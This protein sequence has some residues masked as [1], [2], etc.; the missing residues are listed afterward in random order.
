MGWMIIG[1]WR[2]ALEGI[3]KSAEMLENGGSAGDCVENAIKMVE[4]CPYYESVGCG[5]LP[6]ENGEV[7]LDAGYM[8]GDSLSFGA[9]GGIRDFKNPVSIARRLSQEKVNCFLT[10]SG[11]EEFAHRSGFERKNML[12]ESAAM[13]YRNKL[14]ETGRDLIPYEGHDTVGV[15]ALDKNHSVACGTSTSGLFMKRRGRL[16]DS[17]VC[18]PGFYADSRVG[19]CVATGLGEDIMKGCV[20][21]EA[22]RLME[23]GH[24]PQDAADIAVSKLCGRFAERHR[25]IGDVSVVCLNNRGEFGAATN[26]G[27]FSFAAAAEGLPPAVYVCSVRDGRTVYEAEA[28]NI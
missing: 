16:G 12:T 26:I 19:G 13:R 8:D 2:M 5:G 27:E 20:S 11:A 23:E 9:V 7:E 6:N 15:V 3:A 4:D 22:V 17:P 1:T 28:R 14:N 21:Y 25:E 18:G 24:S 10:G